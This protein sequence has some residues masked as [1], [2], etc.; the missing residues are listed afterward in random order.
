MGKGNGFYYINPS[1]MM[2]GHTCKFGQGRGEG[3]QTG[4]RLN[5]SFMRG[6]KYDIFCLF[7]TVNWSAGATG[8]KGL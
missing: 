7:G 4:L 8:E 6:C 1:H 2:N 5:T 3:R